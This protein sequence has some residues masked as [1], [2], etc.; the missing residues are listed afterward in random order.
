MKSD[1]A[2][3]AL[4]LAIDA[5]DSELDSSITKINDKH[6]ELKKLHIHLIDRQEDL[7]HRHGGADIKLSDII[8]LNV[9]GT[10]MFARRDTLTVVKS[11]RLEALFSGRWENQLLRDDQGRVFMDVDP[12]SF[13]KILEYLYM[14]KISEDN[15][16]PPMSEVDVSMK[17]M[18]DS[19]LDFFKLRSEEKHI[20]KASLL[21]QTSVVS[22]TTGQEEMLVK[23]K[24][25]LD[26][27]EKA[28]ENEESF[29]AF[30]TKDHNDGDT[31]TDESFSGDISFSTSHKSDN[32]CSKPDSMTPARNGIINLYLNGDIV[33]CRVCTLCGDMTSKLA[34]DLSDKSWVREHTIVTEDGK[35]CI[36]VEYPGAEFKA[37]VDYI[38]L[39]SITPGGTT[40]GAKKA[41][42]SMVSKY[43]PRLIKY[44]YGSDSEIVQ[45]ICGT[46]ESTIITSMEDKEKIK[47]WLSSAGNTEQPKLLYRA[48]RDGW[49]AADFHAICDG[50]GATIVVAKSS[51]GYIFGGYTDIAWGIISDY[52]A[53][54]VS[55]LYSLKDH[56]GIGPVKMPIMSDMTESAVYHYLDYGPMFGSNDLHIA[57]NANERTSSQSYIGNM[58]S[59][60]YIGNTY[61]LP[62][63]CSDS[64]FLTG[65][66]HFTVSEYEVFLV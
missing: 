36:L 66:R 53:S 65:S 3:H 19:Y 13:K 10:E 30:F 28:L 5:L 37:L 24:Q 44:L 16:A 42:L 60:I 61:E 46:I 62:V 27:I 49:T 45:L 9:R 4:S 35:A 32:L 26:T 33:A 29:V 41:Q 18:F 57:T 17:D 34:Q 6:Q 22:T 15:D 56:A 1:T 23:M 20:S 52:K 31:A 11:S 38:H 55:F 21:N 25:E 39:K 7:A 54:S 58:S 8:R 64:H 51:D 48:S 47:E 2:K 63:N 43:M 59:Q 50:K 12:K 14:M 40:E